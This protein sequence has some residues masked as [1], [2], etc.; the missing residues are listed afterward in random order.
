MFQHLYLLIKGSIVMKNNNESW[1]K[2]IDAINLELQKMS[3]NT[4]EAVYYLI[5][6][7]TY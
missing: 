6:K 1:G 3:F 4:L 7:L 5:K 2:M